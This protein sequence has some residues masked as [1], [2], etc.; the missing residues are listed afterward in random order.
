MVLLLWFG[1]C[2]AILAAT[3][4]YSVIAESIAARRQEIAIKIALGAPRTRLLRNLIAR[5]LCFVVI[6]EVLGAFA[7][8]WLGAMASELLYGVVLGDPVV[9]GSVTAFVFG[10]SLCAGLWPAW[11]AVDGDS[12]AALHAS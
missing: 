11:S 7:V 3:G 1:V 9:L 4:I 12:S 5:K 8:I 6:G 10:V 2:A